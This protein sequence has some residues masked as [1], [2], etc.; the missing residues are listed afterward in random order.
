MSSLAALK[1]VANDRNPWVCQVD[2]S[3]PSARPGA[4][5]V[6]IP[7]KPFAALKRES[8]ASTALMR[9]RVEIPIKPF[10][11]LKQTNP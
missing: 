4:G 5:G 2:D 6:E 8:T 9:Y 3:L 11:A 1:G 10:A 7:I